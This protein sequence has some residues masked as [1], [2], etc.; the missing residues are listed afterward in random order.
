MNRTVLIFVAIILGCLI[1]GHPEAILPLAVIV[2]IILLIRA[3]LMKLAMK[4]FSQK[5]ND[6]DINVNGTR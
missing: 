4:A 2:G 5:E 1:G 3:G 6:Q